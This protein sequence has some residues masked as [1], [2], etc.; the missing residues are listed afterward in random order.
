MVMQVTSYRSRGGINYFKLCVF[1]DR[2]SMSNQTTAAIA[3][4]GIIL[5]S[6]RRELE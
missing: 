4:A 6:T 5:V 1:R 3:V 2:C